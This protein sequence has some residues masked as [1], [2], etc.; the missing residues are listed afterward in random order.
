MLGEEIE[1][2]IVSS[3]NCAA[4]YI[5]EIWIHGH[6]RTDWLGIMAEYLEADGTPLSYSEDYGRKLFRY[7]QWEQSPVHAVYTRW[8]IENSLGK[9]TAKWTE[10][11][12][13]FVQPN[14]WIYNPEV[15]PTAISKRMRS[16]L[17]MSLAMGSE[18]LVSAGISENLMNHLL[19]AAISLP[20]TGY[21]S[22]EYFRFRT[23]QTLG[24]TEQMV[25][26]VQ[27]T[28]RNCRAGPGFADFDVASKIDDYMGSAKRVGRDVAVF[29]PVSTLQAIALGRGFGIGID[30][31]REWL[32]DTATHLAARPLDVPAF[33]M[34]DLPPEFGGGCTAYE[35]LAAVLLMD[36]AAQEGLLLT[37]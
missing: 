10:L 31:I 2:G 34:R 37:S 29:S 36:Q 28:L 12:G 23:L 11:I 8:W 3:S 13:R 1:N 16:E 22:A 7:P 25:E 4:G 33:H 26:G 24:C 9:N 6:P 15:S 19:G 18:M 35:I 27:D 5:S 17:F 30:S 20:T 14:G 32:N 21:I